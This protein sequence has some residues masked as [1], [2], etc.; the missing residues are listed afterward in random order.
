MPPLQEL[1]DGAQNIWP[2]ALAFLQDLIA[3]PSVNGTDS[4]AAVAYR[5]Q[6]EARRLGITSSLP[7]LDPQR[8]NFLAEVGSG[9][10]GFAFIAHTDTVALG[11]PKEWTYSPLSGRLVDGKIFGRGAADNKAGIACGLYTLALL[12]DKGWLRPGQGQVFMAGVVDEESGA[13]STL[14]VRHLL[15]NNLL[16]AQGAIYAYA[17]DFVCIGHRGLLRFWLIARGKSIHSGSTAWSRGEQGV[18]AVT[19]LADALV[20]LETMLGRTDAHPDFPAMH[21]TITPGTLIQGGDFESIVPSTARA[22]VDVR[23]LPGLTPEQVLRQ[24]RAVLAEVMARRPGLQLTLEEKT[25]VPSVLIPRHHA[26]AQI[27]ADYTE[28]ITGW[29]WPVEGAGPANE[30]YM[31]IESGIPTLCGFGPI[32]GNPH[33]A[34]EWVSV[35]SLIATLAMFS[36]IVVDY[37]DSLG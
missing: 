20:H 9:S 15:N 24:A 36:G 14:G 31:L 37:L 29:R 17:S 25:R 6:E 4:E 1:L 2:Q 28:A 7:A 13:S 8:P 23:L 26:L 30:G 27:A 32:G 19:G 33:T 16:P 12:R 34:D 21:S 35:E 5:A 22:M 18:N 11:D 3:I 10:K